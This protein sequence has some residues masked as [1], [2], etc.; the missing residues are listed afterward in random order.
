MV[1]VMAVWGDAAPEVEAEFGE[2]YF[3]EHV[4][5]RVG[6]P[7]FRSGRRYRRVG[8][9]KHRYLALYEVDDVS[10]LSGGA[11][12]ERL[13][14]PTPWTQSMMPHFRNF[15]RGVFD[16]PARVGEVHGGAI[17]TLRLPKAPEA[18]LDRLGGT[19]L[20]ALQAR[21]GVTRAQLWR[22]NIAQ[23]TVETTEKSMRTDEAEVEPACIAVEAINDAVLRGVLGG[24]MPILREAGIRPRVARYRL[25]FGLEAGGAP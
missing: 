9:G 22:A 15:V 21:E 11:Y 16:V 5:E 8:S 3:R 18:V 20:P 10:V 23:S 19:V 7:G 6:L 17:V 14:N 12:I 1:A 25:M 13:N 24:L 4:P 2:W